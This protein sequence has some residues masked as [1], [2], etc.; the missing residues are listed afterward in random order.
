[1]TRRL[2]L[3]AREA[4][5]EP[6][7]DPRAQRWWHG[8][9]REWLNPGYVDYNKR[10]DA[11]E[12]DWMEDEPHEFDGG[13]GVKYNVDTEEDPIKL[14]ARL[15]CAS[16]PLHSADKVA[17]NDSQDPPPYQNELV[18]PLTYKG[19]R[20]RI[21]YHPDTNAAYNRDELADLNREYE[22]YNVTIAFKYDPEIRD[23][24]NTFYAASGFKGLVR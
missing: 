1:M 18:E 19:I 21:S 8:Y 11:A 9:V 3:R 13:A 10:L 22:R 24:L 4:P 17:L 2:R 6:V 20:F 14:A 15:R 23:T 16:R 7:N 5:G 12:A